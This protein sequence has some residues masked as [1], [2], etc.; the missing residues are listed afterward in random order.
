MLLRRSNFAGGKDYEPFQ[1]YTFFDEINHRS[2]FI[3]KTV[4]DDSMELEESLFLD[5]TVQTAASN[6]VAN[7]N[8]TSLIIRDDD[9]SK[10]LIMLAIW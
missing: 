7:P 4:N 1:N 8:R 2:C 9:I 3:V 10:M 5:F 6:V